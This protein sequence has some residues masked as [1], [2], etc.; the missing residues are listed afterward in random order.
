[1]VK[2]YDVEASDRPANPYLYP[3]IDWGAPPMTDSKGPKMPANSEARKIEAKAFKDPS[4]RLSHQQRWP[5]PNTDGLS[6]YDDVGTSYHW[7]AKWWDQI[8]PNPIGDFPKAFDFGM[9]RLAIADAYVPSKFAWMNDQY[10]DIIVNRPNPAARVKN[11][12]DDINKS[13]LGFL[14]GHA[15]YL[16]VF[17]GKAKESYSNDKYTFVFEDLK[18]PS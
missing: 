4:D 11:G 14:D 5:N 9:Q 8:Y 15:A 12:Y 18:I 3:D 16:T 6:S 13:I 2:G 17:P 1:M 10:A 7:N